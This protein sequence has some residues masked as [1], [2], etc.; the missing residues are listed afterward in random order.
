MGQTSYSAVYDGP[1]AERV[2]THIPPYLWEGS[3]NPFSKR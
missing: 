2:N 1:R 3:I